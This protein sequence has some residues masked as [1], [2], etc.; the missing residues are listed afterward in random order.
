VAEKVV[1]V[2]TGKKWGKARK[3]QSSKFKAQEKRQFP[4]HKG[5]AAVEAGENPKT[6]SRKPKEARI[7]KAEPGT[8]RVVRI[9]AFGFGSDFGPSD[10]RFQ[11]W[12]FF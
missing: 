9:S 4:N 1:E 11:I 12:N 3:A 7:P 6:E 5:V 2:K 10:F 8:R